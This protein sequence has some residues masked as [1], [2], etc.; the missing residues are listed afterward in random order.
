MDYESGA[1]SWLSAYED[2]TFEQQVEAVIEEL[3]PFYEQIHGYVRYKL[4]EYYGDKVVSEK[5]PI[6]MHLLGN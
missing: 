4:R 1:E 3:R 2:E 5:G 6:P